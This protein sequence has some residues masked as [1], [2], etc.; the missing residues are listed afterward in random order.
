MLPNLF[1][2]TITTDQAPDTSSPP[3]TRTV[4][5]SSLRVPVVMIPDLTA[6]GSSNDGLKRKLQEISDDSEGMPFLS[7][8]FLLVGEYCLGDVIH[9]LRF[10]VSELVSSAQHL[11]SR[12]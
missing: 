8:F 2:N 5:L 1:L 6:V 7:F 12:T 9:L 4:I 3:K 11:Q 10:F